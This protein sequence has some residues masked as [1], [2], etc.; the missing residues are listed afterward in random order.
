MKR[1]AD[2]C[3]EFGIPVWIHHNLAPISRGDR[4]T[5]HRYVSEL[6]E[7]YDSCPETTIIHCHAG[8]SRRILL[9]DLVEIH[10]QMLQRYKNVFIDLSWVVFEQ[11]IVVANRFD[12]VGD[13]MI[14]REWISLIEKYPTRFII[15]SDKVGSF[16]S[17]KVE[18]RKWDALLKHLQPKTA[19]L[20][21]S[22]K[23]PSD[24]A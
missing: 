12:V 14:K 23:F 15:G 2:F 17:Y 7:L 22:G 5:G 11:E 6:K 1:I 18:I 21:A 20:V 16:E 3:G 10:D 24:H 9:N 19:D 4:D 13:P 8:I